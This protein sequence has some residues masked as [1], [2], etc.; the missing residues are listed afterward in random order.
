LIANGNEL[1]VPSPAWEQIFQTR[2]CVRPKSTGRVF[3]GLQ[4]GGRLVALD[5]NRLAL[6]VGDFE[7]DG[8]N[9]QP[10]YPQ[11]L[12]SDLGKIIEITLSTR[13]ARIVAFGFRNPQG[14]TL[15]RAGALWE[16][17]HGPQGGDELNL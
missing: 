4:S 2:D 9:A 14:L 15:T 11:D 5:S 3:A 13:A 6:S 7:F 17:E 16:T 8:Y 12:N 1:S 10:A